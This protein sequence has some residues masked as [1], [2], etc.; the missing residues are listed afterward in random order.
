MVDGF[1]AKTPPAA[2]AYRTRAPEI[3]DHDYAVPRTDSVPR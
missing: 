3:A 2:D 1:R